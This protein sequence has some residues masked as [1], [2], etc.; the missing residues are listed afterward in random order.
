MTSSKNTSGDERNITAMLDLLHEYCERPGGQHSISDFISWLRARQKNAIAIDPN[1]IH[2]RSQQ[3]ISALQALQN[4]GADKK[5]A[6]L[7]FDN[8]GIVFTYCERLVE[9]REFGVDDYMLEE[10]LASVF[11]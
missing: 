1:D 8:T 4:I 5:A 7:I 3:F 9:M 11:I 6:Q 10:L 2:Q